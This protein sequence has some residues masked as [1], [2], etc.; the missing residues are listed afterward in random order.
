MMLR[1]SLRSVLAVA[2]L[3]ALGC[4]QVL[5]VGSNQDGGTG[6]SAPNAQGPNAATERPAP[7]FPESECVPVGPAVTLLLTPDPD[8][9]I[10][11]LA[12]D[13]A[14][15]WM[16]T[17][18][19]RAQGFEAR[20]D[21]T[22]AIP[23][24]SVPPSASFDKVVQL[25][26]VFDGKL[27][28]VRNDHA[29]DGTKLDP[30]VDSVVIA[31]PAGGLTTLP[32]PP[33][34]TLV[35]G[36]DVTG[37]GIAWLSRANEANVPLAVM[38]WGTPGPSTAL[39]TIRNHSFTTGDGKEVF[40]VRWEDP[41][42]GGGAERRIEA[43]PVA[44]G[45]PRVLRTM[46]YDGQFFYSVAAVDDTDV[47]FTEQRLVGGGTLDVGEL[48]AM[49]KDGTGERVLASGQ[50]F[51]SYSFRIDPDFLTWTDGDAQDT[52]VR[53]RRTGG[54]LERITTATGNRWVQ[55]TTVDRCNIYW[56]VANPSAIYARS[57]LP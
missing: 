11:H 54:A 33:G 17:R 25:A 42:G 32:H 56:A 29:G 45:T 37:T 46:K 57:R 21:A 20:I 1:S 7:W 14:R 28:F 40:Y 16:E 24:A 52:L 36:L 41:A 53:V 19:S 10:G 38:H 48:R 50:K 39:T 2:P 35:S 26:G 49:K 18:D 9:R 15:L 43:V 34:L 3:L 8:L 13:G 44:G 51:G 6:A 5:D 47:Y 31:D 4:G 55:A 23:G 22:S 30:R 12:A 27:V